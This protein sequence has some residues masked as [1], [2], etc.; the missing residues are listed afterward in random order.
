VISHGGGLTAQQV[1]GLPGTPLVVDYAPQE[2]LLARAV[3]TITHAGLNTVLDSLAKSV[4]LI[5]VPI[6]YEQPAIARRVERTGSG[7]SVALPALNSK[8]L[9]QMA[10]NILGDQNY[11]EAAAQIGGAIANA[12]G[13]VAAANRVEAAAA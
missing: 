9:R 1:A 7:T 10:E 11:R 12:G 8:R 5:T 6:T 13:V 2:E 4:P 3:L